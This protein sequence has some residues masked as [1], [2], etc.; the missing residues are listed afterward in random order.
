[1]TNEE[2]KQGEEDKQVDGAA[3]YIVSSVWRD[4]RIASVDVVCDNVA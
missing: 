1:L 2:Q 4:H 3:V